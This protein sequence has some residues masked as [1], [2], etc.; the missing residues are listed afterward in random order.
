[1]KNF[2]TLKSSTVSAVFDMNGNLTEMTNPVTGRVLFA[3]HIVWRLVADDKVCKETEMTSLGPLEVQETPG[4]LTFTSRRIVSEFG[5]SWPLRVSWSAALSENGICWQ[6]EFGELPENLTVREVQFPVLSIREPEKPMRVHTSRAVSEELIDLPAR[7]RESFSSYMAPDNKY[8]RLDRD[9]IYPG[10][11]NSLNFFLL[12]WENEGLF[13]GCKDARFEMTGHSFEGEKEKINTFMTRFPFKS[14]KGFWRSP[15]FYTIPYCGDFT[16]GAA[17]YRK[18]ADEW[19]TPPSVPAHIRKSQGWQRIILKHQYGEYFFKYADLEKA[20]EEGLKA[21]LDTLFLFGW[22]SEGMDAGYPA[23]T[24]DAS[25][26]G[27][28]ALR[29]SIMKVRKR[30]GHVILYFNG[31]LIETSSA[32]YRSGAGRRACLKREDGT[33]HREYYNF[34]NTGSFC[35]QFIDK[36]FVVACPSSKEWMDILKKHVDFAFE[37]GADSVFFDQLGAAAYPC[38]DPDHGHEVPFVSQMNRK[39]EMLRELYEYTKSKDPEMGLGIECLTDQTAQYSDFVHLV[40]NV[41]QCW[42]SDW[43]QKCEP[44]Q[45][46]AGNYLFKAV[47]PEI[48]ISDRDIQHNADNVIFK[49]NQLVLQG[50]ISDAAVFRCRGSIDKAPLYQEYL[51]KAN[52]LREKYRSTLLE[53]HAVQSRFHR[54]ISDDEVQTNSFISGN[55]LAVVISQSWK[56]EVVCQVEVPGYEIVCCDSISGDTYWDGSALKLPCRSLAVFLCCRTVK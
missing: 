22:T 3:P 24:A 4:R 14:G 33:E 8:L 52:A 45:V 47:F 23:Y 6:L 32:F 53:G 37:V 29:E 46:K 50:L 31:Q 54:I 21:G 9:M 18:W 7:I 34:S 44:P 26:G 11:C 5:Q 10:R 13:Y 41:A 15:E 55:E 48:I 12:Q 42:N 35:R 27:K 2:Y 30:G 19:F 20:Y 51:G 49:V 39:R 28:E 38:C 36:S 25:Q 43:Q 16:K 1:M 56:D 40:G 17:I